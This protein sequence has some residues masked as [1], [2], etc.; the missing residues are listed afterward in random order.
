MIGTSVTDYWLIRTSIALLRAITPLSILY[1]LAGPIFLPVSFPFFLCGIWP[2]AESC[3]YLFAYLPRRYYLQRHCTHPPLASYDERQK[4]FALCQE[5]IPDPEVYLSKW[6]LDSPLEN[7]KRENVKEFYRWAF[8]NTADA[9]PEFDEE[10]ESYVD[11]LET[12]LGRKIEPGRGSATCLRLTIDKVKM[13]SRPLIWYLTVF[14]VDNYTHFSMLRHGFQYYRS[15]MTSI[16]KVFPFRPQVVLTSHV[17][18]V[19]TLS[20]WFR[21]HTSKTK[22]PIVFLHGIGIGLMPYVPFLAALNK[23]H[24]P[25]MADEDDGEVGIIAVEILPISFRITHSAMVKEEM[26]RQLYT[27]IQHHGF[28]KFLLAAHSYGSVITTHLLK[29]PEIRPHIA[30]L[31]LIDPVTILLH[32]PDVAYNFTY[33][34]PRRANEWQLWYFATK[35]MGVAHSLARSFFWSQNILWREDIAELPTTIFL[36]GRDLIVNTHTV[37]GYLTG[38]RGAANGY[39]DVEPSGGGDGNGTGTGPEISMVEEDWK[40]DAAGWESKD[41]ALK[42]VWCEML[43]HA[44]AFDDTQ[45]WLPVLVDEVRRRAVRGPIAEV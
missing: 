10:M 18:P 2:F 34:Q 27:I 17:S 9:S 21:P 25:G 23:H 32:L 40:D 31:V 35:D 44:Q 33:R 20:Y 43:D 12:N 13:Q 24:K 41:G 14:A 11:R 36:G 38:Q 15:P 4:L 42:V 28:D 5:N 16:P 26:C 3:F 7:I 45:R 8:L 30:S 1:C 22:L 29:T 6:F 39:V 19:K 37:A